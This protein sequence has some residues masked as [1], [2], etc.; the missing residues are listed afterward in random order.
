[1]AKY[2]KVPNCQLSPTLIVGYCRGKFSRSKPCALAA[3]VE[4]VAP[5]SLTAIVHHY[6]GRLDHNEVLNAV[7]WVEYT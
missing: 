1:M 5:N 4:L 7:K 3:I 6:M 2:L